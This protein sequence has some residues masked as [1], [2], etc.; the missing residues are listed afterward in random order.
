MLV[1]QVISWGHPNKLPHAKCGLKQKKLFSLRF[2]GHKSEFKATTKHV[3]G[4]VGHIT[5]ECET[6][7]IILLCSALK[8]AH[9]L[10]ALEVLRVLSL[11]F[12]GGGLSL[13]KFCFVL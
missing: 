10:P 8:Q 1:A 5:L 4:T 13:S 12:G 11:T 9:Y 6:V 7:W 3:V 2:M